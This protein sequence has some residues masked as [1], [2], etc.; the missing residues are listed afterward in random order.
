MTVTAY[1]PEPAVEFQGIFV[2]PDHLV[3]TP[4]SELSPASST[5]SG[6]SYSAFDFSDEDGDFSMHGLALDSPA[7]ERG[8]DDDCDDY[9]TFG[10]PS[11]V[12]SNKISTASS[13]STPLGQV[14]NTASSSA[15]MSRSGSSAMGRRASA[16]S[17]TP[18]CSASIYDQNTEHSHFPASLPFSTFSPQSAQAATFSPIL[19]CASPE[20][21]PASAFFSRPSSPTRSRATSPRRSPYSRK[22]SAASIRLVG[23]GAS[24]LRSVSSPVETQREVDQRSSALSRMTSAIDASANQMARAKSVAALP[25]MAPSAPLG[26]LSSSSMG[27][28]GTGLGVS[29]ARGPIRSPFGPSWGAALPPREEAAAPALV[30]F[31]Y[32]LERTGRP[33]PPTRLN[34]SYSLVDTVAAAPQPQP[35]ARRPTLLGPLTPIVPDGA[36]PMQSSQDEAAAAAFVAAVSKTVSPPRTPLQRGRSIC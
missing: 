35:R 29:M 15:G 20:C 36:S 30:P 34:R 7:T 10:S 16:L 31:P 24:M 22:N 28:T 6:L 14:T 19:S 9:F 23:G 18:S 2:H 33:A 4:S 3:G 32:N 13:A 27:R 8:V 21:F 1:L 26:N 11:S 12:Y 25:L 17:R 5:S